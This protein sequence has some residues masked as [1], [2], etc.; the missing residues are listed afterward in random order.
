MSVLRSLNIGVSG[1]SAAGGGISVV[2][3]NI[4]NSSTTGFKASRAE[5]QDVLAKSLK[6]IDGGD[7]FGAGVRLA[8]IKPMMS[9]GDISRTESATDLAISGDGFFRIEA[10]FGSGFSRDGSFHF[11]KEGSLVN[12]DGYKVLGFTA[13]EKGMITNAMEPIKLGNTTV[14]A[15]ASSE[16]EISMNLDVTEAKKEFNIEDPEN[17]SS[18]ASSVTVYD[19]VG[20]ARLV[21]LYFNKIDNNNWEYHATVDGADAEGGTKG[22]MV[23]MA[24]GN[25]VFNDE[26]LL[27][28]EKESKNSFNFGQG[29]K[30]DQKIKFNFGESLKEG[31]NGLMASTQYGSKSTIARHFQDGYSAATLGSISF[32]DDGVLTAVYTNGINRDIAQINVTR[33][34]DNESLF[35]MGKNLYKETRKSGQGVNGKP[36]EGGRGSIMSKSLELSNVDIAHE[37]V[38]LMNQQ[39]NF[40]ANTKTLQA[41]DQMLQ[42]VLAI[43]R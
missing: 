32:N 29:A 4:S 41:A 16:V 13:D 24:K 2:A 42:D 38:Q 10:P 22:K 43:K 26:G 17:T 33:F 36:S 20:T 34:E 37:F 39:R 35:K 40:S 14:P 27:Q 6:G 11:D 23:E 31:G 19:N 7:Q 15:R 21:S 25:L 18:Y 9:Q 8:H 30:P 1:L 3:D 12:S 5:F 28:E